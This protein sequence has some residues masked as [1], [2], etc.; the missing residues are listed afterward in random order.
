MQIYIL[1]Q[2]YQKYLMLPM[3][4][5]ELWEICRAFGKGKKVRGGDG[6]KK[7]NK[8]MIVVYCTVS[9]S[10]L[11]VSMTLE[12]RSEMLSAC[13]SLIIFHKSLFFFLAAC[14]LHHLIW[15]SHGSVSSSTFLCFTTEKVSLII[16]T[17]LH[18]QSHYS[19]VRTTNTVH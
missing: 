7:K 15:I 18:G 6:G 11:K 14:L 1:R 9:S 5:R 19:V 3:G 12:M 17:L 2:N 4:R 16:L 8:Y 10:R 13:A